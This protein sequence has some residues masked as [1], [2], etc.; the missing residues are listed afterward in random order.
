MLESKIKESVLRLEKGDLTAMD[1]EA[2]V[3]Y[4]QHNLKLGS[5]FGNAIAVRGGV[6]IQGE[7]DKLSEASTCDVV[8]TGAGELKSNY[9]IHAVGPRFQEEDTENKLRKTMQNALDAAKNKGII[10]IAFPPMGTGFYGIPLD[11]CARVMLETIK[12]H[13]AGS[14]TLKEVVICAMD[15]REYKPFQV[16]WERTNIIKEKI[17]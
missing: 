17:Q 5:G 15:E 16:I 10:K 8:V 7:L 6:S 11:M 9:I 2:I 12:E 4:A 3:F 1:I 14:T 13:L